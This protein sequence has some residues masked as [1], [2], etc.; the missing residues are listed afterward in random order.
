MDPKTLQINLLLL[1]KK[2]KKSK[3]SKMKCVLNILW[4]QTFD[5]AERML[6]LISAMGFVGN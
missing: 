6:L 3:F 4:K 2:K 5:F 1:K